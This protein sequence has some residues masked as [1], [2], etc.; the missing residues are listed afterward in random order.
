MKKIIPSCHPDRKHYAYG[1]CRSCWHTYRYRND[2]IYREKF[3]ERV[4]KCYLRK[5]EKDPEWNA[6]KQKEYRKN[7]PERF[8]YLMARYYFRKLS[9][10]SRK[11]LLKDCNTFQYKSQEAKNG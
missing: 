2:P 9:P 4:K 8:N 3:K 5:S 10:E 7:H 11:Q 1:L 6:R